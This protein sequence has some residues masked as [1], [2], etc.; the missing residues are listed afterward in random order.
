MV[1]V[2]NENL[3]RNKVMTIKIHREAKKKSKNALKT[4]RNS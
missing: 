2:A 1:N 3:F 4:L